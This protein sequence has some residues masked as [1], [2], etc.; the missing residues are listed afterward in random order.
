M[1]GNIRVGHFKECFG[2][3]QLTS[4]NYTTFM[5]RSIDDEGAF[6][7]G[8]NDGIMVF[9]WTKDERA[10]WAVGA[11]TNQTGFD[12]P[13][14]FQFDHGGLDVASRGTYLVWYDEGSNGRGVFHTGLDFAYRSAPNDI[15]IMA[16]KPESAFAPAVINLNLPNVDHWDVGEWKPHWSMGRFPSSRSCLLPPSTI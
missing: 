12:Q 3:E 1:I 10:T 7:P 8:R 4:D 14:T 6:V 13:P 9:D 5:E 15:A 2:L 16:A 11:F